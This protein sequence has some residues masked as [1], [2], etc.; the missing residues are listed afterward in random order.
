MNTLFAAAIALVALLLT[1]CGST[2][3]VTAIETTVTSTV[4]VTEEA[5]APPPV[6]VTE[7]VAPDPE[8]VE[9]NL[10]MFMDDPDMQRAALDI[11]WSQMSSSDQADICL[12]WSLTD[13]RPD[14]LDQFL[15]SSDGMFDRD[16]V[17]DYFDEV[18]G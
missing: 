7:T 14:L 8:M 12:G 1:G 15:V 4:T 5:P 17:E 10:D 9:E 16:L 3:E 11:S 6:T 2:P 13:L 18:C